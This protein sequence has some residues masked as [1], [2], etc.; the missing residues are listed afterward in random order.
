MTPAT[1][2][3]RKQLQQFIEDV[4]IGETAVKGV[5]AIGS[6]ATGHMTPQSD[7][8]AIIFFDPFDY[9]IVPAEAI[10]QPDE[11]TFYSI[12]NEQ[13]KG[14]PLD[15]AR[16]NWQQWANPDFVWPEG[17]KAELSMG[18]IVYD[19]DSA[20]KNL[21]I[22]R[23]AYPDDLRLARLDES[24]IWLDQH[25]NNDVPQQ[26]WQTLGPV[27]AHDRLGAAY[28]YLVQALFAYNRQWR[29]WRNREMQTLLNLAWLPREFEMRV[30]TAVTA[31]NLE[32]DG[33]M[34]RVQTLSDLFEELLSQLITN[35]DYSNTPIDQA[36][37]RSNEEPGRAW[38]MDEWNKFRRAR[39]LT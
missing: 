15:F 1:E 32:N 34:I 13:H 37:I 31:P 8:D 3:K 22:Q 11:D 7:I 23:T 26:I 28:H 2:E 20:V 16:L 18:W 21:I 9:Y 33:Y 14:I 4:L 30:L 10:W 17:R 38:N 12:F 35:G 39:L 24:I 25:L 36:F 19:P 5:V 29:P 6:M 27:V